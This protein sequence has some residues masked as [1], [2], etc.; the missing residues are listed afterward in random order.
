MASAMMGAKAAATQT[1]IAAE[2][3][4]MNA[5]AAASIVQV[6]EAAQQNI[7]RLVNVAPGVGGNVDISA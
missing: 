6:L 3:M 2:M 1:A 7:S 5:E 4:K